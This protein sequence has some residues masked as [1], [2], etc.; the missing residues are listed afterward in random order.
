M[1]RRKID[2]GVCQ[3]F[4]Y[5]VVS[6]LV[7]FSFIPYVL[8]YIFPSSPLT[9]ALSKFNHFRTSVDCLAMPLVSISPE[10][11]AVMYNLN[12][13]LARARTTLPLRTLLSRSGA[14]LQDSLSIREN[15]FRSIDCSVCVHLHN[16]YDSTN[17]TVVHLFFSQ[18]NLSSTD[19]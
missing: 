14:G 13:S 11:D 8:A 19:W 17:W 1:R 10:E 16:L 3:V 9:Y 4:V 5:C 18:P 7:L 6:S 2:L 15:C 12:S